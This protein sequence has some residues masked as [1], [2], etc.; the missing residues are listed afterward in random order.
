APGRRPSGAGPDRGGVGDG[1]RP[2]RGRLVQA[3]TGRSAAA[4][5][6]RYNPSPMDFD[7]F[8]G[9]ALVRRGLEDLA[10]GKENEAALLVAVGAPRLRQLGI[11]VPAF[12]P[13][14]AVVEHR[15]YRRLALVDPDAAHSRYNALI[16]CLVSFERAAGCAS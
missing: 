4:Q 16:R 5:R 6:L 2:G 11:M 12:S 10:A 13:S 7:R 14:A 1:A 15:L 9:G 8:P 3:R